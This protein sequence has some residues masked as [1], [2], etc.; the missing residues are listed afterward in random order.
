MEDKS[1][2]GSFKVPKGYF[3]EFPER[4]DDRLKGRL[5]EISSDSNGFKVPDHYFQDF[6]HRLQIRLAPRKK[7]DI[8]FWRS[9]KLLWSSAVAASLLLLLMLRPYYQ[10]QD[11]DFEDLA[12]TEIEDYLEVRYDEL[13]TFELA[14]SLPFSEVSYSDVMEEMPHE[15]QI[16]NYLEHKTEAYDHYNFEN[17]E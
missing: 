5:L 6:E 9:P 1:K 11:P 13:S 17:D 2:Y 7:A 4:L 15:N 14:E 8:P 12:R 16:L 3:E 10:T